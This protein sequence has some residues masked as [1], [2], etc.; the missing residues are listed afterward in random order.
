MARDDFYSK[1]YCRKATFTPKVVKK[2]LTIKV[3]KKKDLPSKT[4]SN[5]TSLKELFDD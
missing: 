2:P 3:V 1:H 4:K 5:P